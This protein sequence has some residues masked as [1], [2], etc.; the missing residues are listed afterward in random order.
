MIVRYKL[1]DSRPAIILVAEVELIG[2]ACNIHPLSTDLKS[3]VIDPISN[4]RY[5]WIV[6]E[7]FNIGKTD[8]TDLYLRTRFDEEEE[9]PDHD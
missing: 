5:D 7:L 8:I 1:K 2:T 3:I 4:D 6:G 9:V